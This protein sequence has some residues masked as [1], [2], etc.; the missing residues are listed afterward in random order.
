ME[1]RDAARP[2]L[3]SRAL[4]VRQVWEWRKRVL[5]AVF[6]EEP[7]LAGHSAD[8]LT[9]LMVMPVNGPTLPSAP[10]ASVYPE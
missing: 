7:D 10:H 1:D 2:N 6:L 8:L 9:F 3:P 5:P 4:Q